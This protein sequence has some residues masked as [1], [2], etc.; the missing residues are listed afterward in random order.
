[1]PISTDYSELLR[2]TADHVKSQNYPAPRI[3]VGYITDMT[4]ASDAFLGRRLT[5]GAT[6]M[7]MTALS[8]AGMRLVERLDMGV[9][10]VD[11]DYSRAGLIKD[12]PRQLREVHAGQIQGADLYVV[13]G[14]T[15]F[16]PNIVSGGTNFYVGGSSASA[17]ALAI[18]RNHYVIDIGIDLRLVD[19]RSSDILSI[20]SFR[21]Q[22][23]GYENELGTFD[24]IGS[25]VGDIGAGRKALEPI[26]TA[27]RSMIDRAMLEFVSGLYNL[28]KTVCGSD[29]TTTMA[30]TA[31]GNY[32]PNAR[33]AFQLNNRLAA[34]V[35]PK[36]V[37]PVAKPAPQK[38]S[39]PAPKKKAAATI[40]ASPPPGAT[41]PAPQKTPTKTASDAVATVRA[42]GPTDTPVSSSNSL[43]R[44]RKLR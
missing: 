21:K 2:C 39:R 34:V 37:A 40:P 31:Y 29:F 7:A 32:G 14:I 25:V 24:I 13:G 10:Q 19:A 23:V 22:I 35:P 3:A 44:M 11:L 36:P 26:Q 20:R 43:G 1:M 4:G 8:D 30:S 9:L 38:P 15:E 16:N 17:G 27:V 12:S 5:Q 6:L 33:G 41:A 28:D 42:A 18:G